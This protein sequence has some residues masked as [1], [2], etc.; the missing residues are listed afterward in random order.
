MRD[1]F[2]RQ[3]M[4]LEQTGGYLYIIENKGLGEL[5]FGRTTK[6]IYSSYASSSRSNPNNLKVRANHFFENAS[7]DDLKFIEDR[8]KKDPIV[9]AKKIRG[10]NSE[11]LEGMLFDYLDDIIHKE[12]IDWRSNQGGLQQL[13]KYNP[14]ED[15]I[16]NVLKKALEKRTERQTSPSI[17]VCSIQPAEV[18]NKKSLY[19][20]L[21]KSISINSS[22]KHNRES[23]PMQM[24]LLC[25]RLGVDSN[26]ANWKAISIWLKRNSITPRR[27]NGK[28][29][30]DLAF[31]N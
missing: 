20:L 25:Q 7:A 15:S 2:L 1:C 23:S 30:Y 26:M 27:T 13:I 29:V 3:K 6:N 5:K 16:R 31:V 4:S 19:S 14:D 17:K 24:T 18:Q 12:Y 8:I 28:K 11:W 21:R 10:S 9:N 22:N